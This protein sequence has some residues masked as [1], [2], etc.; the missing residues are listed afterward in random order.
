MKRKKPHRKG[1]RRVDRKLSRRKELELGTKGW[2]KN[3]Y[4]TTT[5]EEIAVTS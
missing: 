3:E 1:T 4:S 2:T 5:T